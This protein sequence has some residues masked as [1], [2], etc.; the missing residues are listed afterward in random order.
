MSVG[1]FFVAGCRRLGRRGVAA[2]E[3][4]LV[5]PVMLVVLS[6]A[7]DIANEVIAQSQLTAAVSA[8]TN[9]AILNVASVGTANEATMASNI[10]TIVSSSN[11]SNWANASVLVNNG[12]TETITGGSA[13]AGGSTSGASNCYCPTGS[14]SSITWGSAVVCGSACSGGGYAG[15]FV[16]ISGSYSFSPILPTNSFPTSGTLTSYAMVQVQ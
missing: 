9:Y 15:K 2:L 14:G 16:Y 3:F 12:S 4:A 1:H 8:A 10:A 7:V 5:A 11:A 6:A 13:S